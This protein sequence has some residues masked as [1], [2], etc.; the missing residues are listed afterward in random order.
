MSAFPV[1]DGVTTFSA[2]P[3]GYVVNFDHPQQQKVMEHY[4]LFGIGGTFAFIALL[5]RFY[6]KIY[7]SKGLQIDD[8]E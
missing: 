6:T 8:G 5:Q 1:T 3:D 7:L 2:P 4:L